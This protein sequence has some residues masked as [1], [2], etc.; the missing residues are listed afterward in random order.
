MDELR[1]YVTYMGETR[2]A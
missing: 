1:E 2:Y